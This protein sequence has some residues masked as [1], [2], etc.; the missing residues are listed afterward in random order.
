MRK[1][2]SVSTR[3]SNL[4][5]FALSPDGPSTSDESN[6]KNISRS[7]RNLADDLS[8]GGGESNATSSG[9]TGRLNSKAP[10]NFATSSRSNR[11]HI[12]RSLGGQLR[13]RQTIEMLTF[14]NHTRCGCVPA[15]ACGR[16]YT[17]PSHI[18]SVTLYA[19]LHIR[20]SNWNFPFATSTWHLFRLNYRAIS[21]AMIGRGPLL[22][23]ALSETPC[24]PSSLIW[25][26]WTPFHRPDDVSNGFWKRLAIITYFAYP[27][28][29]LEMAGITRR[30][31]R[32][33]RFLTQ[34]PSILPSN[35]AII[36]ALWS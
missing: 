21:M 6:G 22:G 12:R 17:S 20:V 10:F 26:L 29:S 8:A 36:I 31:Y 5:N 2:F 32:L 13:P 11:N 16:S 27:L 30:S 18:N 15:W 14:T 33:L 35:N 19:C 4:L 9:R 23:R 3:L 28:N 25:L 7:R 1:P 34:S 24:D